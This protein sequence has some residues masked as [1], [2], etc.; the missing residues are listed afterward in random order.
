MIY[1]II[2]SLQEAQGSLAKQ[3]ILDANKG[4]ELLKNFMQATYDPAV[5]YYVTK[6]PKVAPA[7]VASFD[8][9]LI[10]WMLLNIAGRIYTGKTAETLLKSNMAALDAEGQELLTLMVKRSI[11]A[12]V[13]D[14]MVLKTW[15]DLYFIPPYQRCS[16]MDDKI[17]A[18]FEQ[19]DTFYIQPKLDG[20]F[21]YLVTG[22]QYLNEGITR[23][24]SKYPQWFADRLAGELQNL[25]TRSVFVGE[26]EV[27]REDASDLE[28][29]KYHLLPRQEGNGLLNAVLKGRDEEEFAEYSF[30]LTAWDVL[31]E[32]E[33][34]DGVSRTKYKYRLTDL[35]D[36]LDS[37]PNACVEAIETQ[38]VSSLEEAY[39]IYSSFTA[40]GMEGAVI[41]N[42]ESL[43]KDGTSKDLV[44]LKIAFEAD[45]VITAVV[46]GQGK[47]AGMMGAISIATDDGL[48]QCDV[49]TGFTDAMRKDFWDNQHDRV[50]RIVTIIANDV[51]VKR[52]SD[53]RSL[54][55]PVYSDL[56]FDKTES[57]ADSL[58]R[59]MEQLNAAKGL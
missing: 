7:N 36:T 42:P 43:W 56:R 31:D 11:G 45:Y 18:K 13:G 51:L 37:F 47:A 46:E 16:L 3:A 55:L 27:Y 34:K 59:V 49:G 35:K 57:E 15:P 44:K 20:S 33:F 41:K 14:T 25:T 39:K 50:G 32:D 8:Q 30:K 23:A 40:K 17:K 53:I 48:L 58:E 54:F 26:V 22:A 29:F 24:G 9:D 19:R 2:K 6:L 10:D 12:S 5:N 38:T 1:K 28:N 4:N 21:L 52:D